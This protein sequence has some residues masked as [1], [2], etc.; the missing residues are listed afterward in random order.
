LRITHSCEKCFYNTELTVPEKL[1]KNHTKDKTKKSCQKN[2][3]Q[4]LY[5]LK[6][7]CQNLPKKILFVKNIKK[8][9]KPA[10][11]PKQWFSGKI[12]QRRQNGNPGTI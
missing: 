7:F 5:I 4:I 12:C 10:K 1:K 6:K 2:I 11:W 8:A 3:K 9:K